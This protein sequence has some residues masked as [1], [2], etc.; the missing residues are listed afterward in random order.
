MSRTKRSIEVLKNNWHYKRN[1]WQDFKASCITDYDGDMNSYR[2]KSRH[3][4]SHLV[5][6]RDDI[7][8]AASY[9]VK[10]LSQARG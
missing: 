7:Y 5:S 3:K 4:A 8:P 10:Y 9:E 6:A 1:H 2:I